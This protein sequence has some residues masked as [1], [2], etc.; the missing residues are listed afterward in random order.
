[1]PRIRNDS[2][3]FC[4]PGA[5]V[6]ID[7]FDLSEA[8]KK[9]LPGLM[10]RETHISSMDSTALMVAASRQAI[11]R[12]PND[13]GTIRMVISAP[14]LVSS[15]GLEIP[16]V[17]VCAELGLKDAECLNIS[18]GC[19]GILRAIDLAKKFI[20]TEPERGSILVVTSCRASPYTQ[21]MNHGAFFWGDG[22]AALI[23]TADDVPGLEVV[24]YAEAS[25]T[26]DWGAMRIDFG[27]AASID[28]EQNRDGL[29]FTHFDN[30]ERQMDY[31]RSE[32]VRFSSVINSL[33]HSQHLQEADI[34]SI[35]L[36]STGKNRV[37]LLFGDHEILQKAVKIQFDSGHFGGVDMFRSIYLD[38]KTETPPS[39]TWCIA[40]S[41]AFAAQWGGLLLRHAS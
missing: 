19:V 1:M 20:Q 36:P 6:A 18:Q 9:R 7:S 40:A 17:A 12:Y 16:A 39:G 21:N 22:A 23:V 26:A 24:S 37:P 38:I 32:Q 10:Q 34:A 28:C 30:A 14:S 2:F 15:Y 29:I 25:N 31:I 13:P 3:G 41:P 5:P 8:E 35:Y 11:E 27:D 33:F 4:F